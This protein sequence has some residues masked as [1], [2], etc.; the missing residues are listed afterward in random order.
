MLQLIFGLIK[1]AWLAVF[2]FSICTILAWNSVKI[3]A[4]HRLVS[5]QRDSQALQ[6]NR[7]ASKPLFWCV[8]CVVEAVFYF[9][10][11]NTHRTRLQRVI[12]ARFRSVG[13]WVRTLW[14]SEEWAPWFKTIIMEVWWSYSKG[15]NYW[16]WLSERSRTKSFWLEERSNCSRRKITFL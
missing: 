8:S 13:F 5:S 15:S 3:E 9:N 11:Q 7:L 2:S 6:K 16:P 12:L 14:S 10:S 4:K 1:S